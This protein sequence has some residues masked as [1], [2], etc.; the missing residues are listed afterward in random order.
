ML[1]FEDGR[2]R[3]VRRLKDI[4]SA[5]AQD[6][7]GADRCSEARLQLIRRFA[8]ACVLAEQVEAALARGEE[9]DAER[10]ALVVSTMCR[11]AG[12]VGIDRLPREIEPLGSYLERKYAA[13]PAEPA[14]DG[15]S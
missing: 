5:I 3:V 10:F 4:A 13:E 8:T 1:A 11:L 7:G 2:R 14:E 6:Q 12:R 9:L 15:A